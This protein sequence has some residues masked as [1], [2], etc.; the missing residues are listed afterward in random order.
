M[1]EPLFKNSFKRDENSIKE[2]CKQMYF[3]F[4][5]L[6]P[7]CILAAFYVLFFIISYVFKSPWGDPLVIY[8]FL[9]FCISVAIGTIINYRRSVKNAIQREKELGNNGTLMQELSVF[10]DK[11]IFQMRGNTLTIEFENITSFGMTN[12]YVYLIS[13]GKVW[14]DFKKRLLH[15][16]QC[17][18]IY[19][20]FEI[21]GNKGAKISLKR[22]QFEVKNEQKRKIYSIRGH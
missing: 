5:R 20:I 13:K 16:R 12:N 6:A 1:N 15:A 14:Y 8:F 4:A 19:R 10:E 11:V 9:I 7:L 18:G 3:S 17:G 21:E 22:W 2:M